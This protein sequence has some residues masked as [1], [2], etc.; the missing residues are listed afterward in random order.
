MKLRRPAIVGVLLAVLLTVL[1]AARP[2]RRRAHRAVPR[3]HRRPGGARGRRPRRHHEGPL[4]RG[5]PE[6]RDPGRGRRRGRQPEAEPRL[7]RRDHALLLRQRQPR[8]AGRGDAPAGDAGRRARPGDQRGPQGLPPRHDL[9][10]QRHLRRRDGPR[11]PP[12]RPP[13]GRPAVGQRRPGG[14]GVRDVPRL[15]VRRPGQRPDRRPQGVRRRHLGRG[16][17]GVDDR[18]SRRCSRRR[19]TTRSAGS[20]G[21]TPATTT[22]SRASGWTSPTA[23]RSSSAAGPRTRAGAVGCR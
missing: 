23:S 5:A 17:G 10:P 14:A 1:A 20:R 4:R 12:V 19:P 15:G 21:S 16:H 11:P 9:V 3:R 8:R 6:R 2:A 22:G 18:R 13:G 7:G